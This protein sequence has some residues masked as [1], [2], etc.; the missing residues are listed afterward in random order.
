MNLMKA[1]LNKISEIG[2]GDEKN[3]YNRRPVILTNL[4]AAFV[5]FFAIL[6]TATNIATGYY[7]NLSVFVAPSY[8]FSMMFVFILNYYKKHKLAS[9]IL[10]WLSMGFLITGSVFLGRDA[11]MHLYLITGI[12]FSFFI[13]K[14]DSPFSRYLLV[15]AFFI[16]FMILNIYNFGP[17]LGKYKNEEFISI[18]RTVNLMGLGLLIILFGFSLFTTILKTDNTLKINSYELQ[19]RTD[20]L[21]AELTIARKVQEQIIPQQNPQIPG[22]TIHTVYRPMLEVGGDLYDFISFKGNN[23]IGIFISDVSG[24]GVQAAFITSMVKTIINSSEKEKDSTSLLLSNINAKII[25]LIGNNFLTAFYAIYDVSKKV[26][27]YSRGGHNYPFLIRDKKV[28]HLESKGRTIGILNK[29]NFEEKEILLQSDD[30]III[31]TDGLTEALNQKQEEFEDHLID[32]ILVANTDKSINNY[33]DMI[34][35]N[36]IHFHNS[37]EFED[38]VCIIGM[39]VE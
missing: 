12:F 22:L 16:S 24:H 32:N 20:E 27:K 35:K 28:I 31:Y 23:K 25:D 4:M 18:I 38:D 5:S 26:L 10:A 8:T 13:F 36:L 11:Y 30:K 29:S 9:H 7:T 17:I 19:K 2:I 14:N 39:Q 34:Y 6:I 1:V 3:A 33:V 21:Q 15:F 37:D